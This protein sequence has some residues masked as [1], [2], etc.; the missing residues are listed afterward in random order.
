[1]RAH[2]LRLPITSAPSLVFTVIA[3]CPG[4]FA[5]PAPNTAALDALLVRMKASAMRYQGRLPD[6]TCTEVTVRKEDSSGNGA[7]WRTLDTLEELVSFASSGH[8]SKTLVKK[9][10]R[11]TTKKKPGGLI[12]NAVLSGAIVPRGI[13][14]AKAQPKFDWDHW[15][16]RS[17]HRIAVIVYQAVG[18]NY[19]D[20]KTR[21]EL[22]VTGRIVFD[23][24]AGNLIRTE[25]SSV[26]P[27]GYPF[28]EVLVET[29]YAPV[30]I[31]DRELILPTRAVMTTV[32][33][34]RRY[35]SEIQFSGYRKYQA[36]TTI[37]FEDRR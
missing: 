16:T 17:E 34:K 27:L 7:N 19:P 32:R 25:S 9:N 11:R 1:M 10:G 15:E 23:D 30:T 29:D 28:G 2:R 31:S 18:E 22:K 21:Y 12:E 13:F 5:Q 8:V 4:V 33:G 14:G 3:T 35:Q 24:T 37:R 6:F 36:D 20:G 26:G